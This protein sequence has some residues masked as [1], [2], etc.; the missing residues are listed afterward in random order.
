MLLRTP[1]CCAVLS[2]TSASG[3]TREENLELHQFA[4]AC[5]DEGTSIRPSVKSTGRCRGTLTAMRKQ[6]HFWPG[7]QGLDAWDVDRLIQLTREL[8][9]QQ[10]ELSSIW[11]VDSTYWFDDVS[12]RPTVRNIVDHVRLI[13]EVDPSY[14]VILGVD[15][16]VMDGMHRVARAMIEGP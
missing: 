9:V 8:P 6:Y 1:S 4:S 13:L 7:E 2:R 11:E 3:E 12:E 16:R 10:V 15:G 14:P 5:R